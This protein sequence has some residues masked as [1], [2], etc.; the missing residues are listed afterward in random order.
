[1]SYQNY[2]SEPAPAQTSKMA[3]WSVVLGVLAV[4][5]AVVGIGLIF[6]VIGLVLGIM[7]MSAISKRPYELG[8]KGMALAGT[9]V[10]GISLLLTPVCLLLVAILLPSLGRARELSNRSYCAANLRGLAQSM[11]VYAA[12]Q[13]D[14]FPIVKP[15][16]PGSYSFASA[17]NSGQT[18]QNTALEQYYAGSAGRGSVTAGWWILVLKNQVSPKQFL[19]KSDPVG[20]AAPAPLTNASGQYQLDFASPNQF[21]Y[22]SAYPWVGTSVGGWWKNITDASLPIMSD[23]APKQGTGSPAAD[24][25]NPFAGRAANSVNHTRDGQNVVFSDCHAEFCRRPDVGQNMDNI[26]TQNGS[27]GPSERGRT[28]SGGSVGP[29]YGTPSSPYDVIM[30]PIR[31]ASTGITY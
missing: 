11:N 4:V 29:G 27:S 1:M 2:Q 14:M 31:D 20:S 7:A 24:P 15:G 23:I 10:S 8:G 25:S 26:W 3:I 12:D 21:S 30:V 6:G 13:A 9:I 19:C 22:S 16:A 28:I 5:T 18:N 17:G